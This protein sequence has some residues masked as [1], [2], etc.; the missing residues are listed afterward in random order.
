M[1]WELTVIG[2]SVDGFSSEIENGLVGDIEKLVML[3]LLKMKNVLQSTES[4][5]MI[6]NWSVKLL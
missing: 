3:F 1:I 5:M 4:G 6:V 2:I